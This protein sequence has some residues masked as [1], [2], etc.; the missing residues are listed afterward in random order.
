MGG[1]LNNFED[2]DQVFNTTVKTNSFN[3]VFMIKYTTMLSDHLANPAKE[4]DRGKVR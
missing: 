4:I 3:G 2:N 1:I